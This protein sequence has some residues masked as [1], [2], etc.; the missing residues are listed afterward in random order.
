M[1]SDELS[2]IVSLNGELRPEYDETLLKTVFVGNMLS[3]PLLAQTLFA[4]IQMLPMLFL[5]KKLLTKPYDSY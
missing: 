2:D 5:M 1:F 4:L 3:S